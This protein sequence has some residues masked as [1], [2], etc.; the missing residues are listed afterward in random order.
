MVLGKSDSVNVGLKGPKSG[1]WKYGEYFYAE[2]N[3]TVAPQIR[4]T[5][6]FNESKILLKNPKIT[7]TFTSGN[8]SY[9]DWT[10]KS[11]LMEIHLRIIPLLKEVMALSYRLMM[12]PMRCFK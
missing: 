11:K 5:I 7:D 10:L 1:I 9:V 3:P 6:G 8:Y 4:W 12:R 2:E